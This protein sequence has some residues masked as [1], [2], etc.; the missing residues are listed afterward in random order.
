[1]ELV[2][3]HLG[4]DAGRALAAEALPLLLKEHEYWTQG[5]RVGPSLGISRA[6]PAPPSTCLAPSDTLRRSHPSRARLSTRHASSISLSLRLSRL[7]A[8]P[9]PKSVSVS[10]PSGELHRLSRYFADWALPRPESWREDAELAEG[11]PEE[12]VR[13]LASLEIARSFSALPCAFG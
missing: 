1:M 6:I 12:E 8:S 13:P 10:C 5:A 11:L 2:A 7:I 3:R 4:G 9:G